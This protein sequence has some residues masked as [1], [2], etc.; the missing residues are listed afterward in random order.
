MMMMMVPQKV[1]DEFPCKFCGWWILGKES[2]AVHYNL[3]PERTEN[4]IWITCFPVGLIC[5]ILYFN[6]GLYFLGK[7]WLCHDGLL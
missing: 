4:L 2:H 1:V 3:H 6:G 7:W 5:K